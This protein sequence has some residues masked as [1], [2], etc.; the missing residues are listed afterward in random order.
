MKKDEHFTE[1]SGKAGKPTSAERAFIA[2]AYSGK[3]ADCSTFTINEKKIS[4][5]LFEAILTG[6]FS[7][8]DFPEWVLSSVGVRLSGAEIV[9]DVFLERSNVINTVS[10]REVA[11]KGTVDLEQCNLNG[12]LILSECRLEDT[13]YLSGAKLEGSFQAVNCKFGNA[14]EDSGKDQREFLLSANNISAG[15]FALVDCEV[16]GS[17]ELIGAQLRG[18]LRLDGPSMAIVAMEEALVADRISCDSV[19]LDSARIE[20]GVSLKE[21]RVNGFLSAIGTTIQADCTDAISASGLHA[22]SCSFAMAN[23]TG[24]LNFMGAA[25]KGQFLANGAALHNPCGDALSADFGNFGGFFFTPGAPD[26]ETRVPKPFKSDGCINLSLVNVATIIRFSNASLVSNNIQALSLRAANVEGEIE[27]RDTEI[28]GHIYGDNLRVEGRMS[29]IGD[30]KLAAST[31]TSESIIVENNDNQNTRE[32]FKHHALVMREARVQG[33]LILP[34]I[35][36]VGIVDLSSA[37]C[38]TLEDFG[39]GWPEH[40]KNSPEAGDQ[41]EGQSPQFLVLDGF[42]YDY[43]ENPSGHTTS[44]KRI[45]DCRVEW[46][47]AQDI[48]DIEFHFN[49]QPWRQLSQVLSRMGYEDEAQQI[50]IEGKNLKRKAQD[51]PRRSKIES[52][53]LQVTAEYGFNPWRTLAI[54]IICILIFASF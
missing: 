36:P 25:I 21:A 31:I 18:T 33:R 12:D 53:I 24:K 16:F 28:E 5:A 46:L 29:F 14:K 44:A 45:S 47:K 7:S 32:K 2:A 23:I 51:T 37:K 39:S 38:G 9:G 54:S 49:P 35:C 42:E 4:A 26:P 8:P 41:G 50:S 13:F 52:F 17:I 3:E 27:F 48:S 30:T 34:K 43:L 1:F 6:S 19:V 20:G 15:V 40:D 10:L 11:F 22:D